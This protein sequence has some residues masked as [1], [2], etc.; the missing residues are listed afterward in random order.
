MLTSK[1]ANKTC[2]FGTR[3][4]FSAAAFSAL[5]EQGTPI[6]SVFCAS[7]GPAKPPEALL[8]VSNPPEVETLESLAY[9]HDIPIRYVPDLTG[10]N[11]LNLQEI[12]KPDFILV[13]CFPYRLPATITRWPVSG[14]LNI[15]P[16]LLPKYRGPDPIFWQLHNNESQ[17]GISLHFVSSEMDAGPVITQ[18][19]CLLKEGSNRHEIES[20]FARAGAELFT[21]F[22]NNKRAHDIPGQKQE[23]S[24]ASYN[25]IPSPQNYEIPSSWGAEHAFNFIRGTN[26]PTGYYI[27][28]SENNSFNVTTALEYSHDNKI[29]K[30]SQQ[31]KNEL[32]IQ[33][34][35][36]ILH[37]TIE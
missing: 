9:R 24:L 4:Q 36:G 6:S 34:S 33:F 18:K 14:C 31:I 29:V 11:S 3:G 13:A 25:A 35:P 37:V 19:N 7:V 2:F 10:L 23:E 17:T 16:S 8:P 26:S 5:L 30:P 1:I 28:K 32:L 21:S 27:I 22:I 20:L 15:H 12:D